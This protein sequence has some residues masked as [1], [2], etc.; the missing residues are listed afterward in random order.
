M[1]YFLTFLL[2]QRN[3][4]ICKNFQNLSRHPHPK[5]HPSRRLYHNI[6]LSLFL[7]S[8]LGEVLCWRCRGQRT[9]SV[10]MMMKNMVLL[11]FRSPLPI[12]STPPHPSFLFFHP[13]TPPPYRNPRPQP[14]R[15]PPLHLPLISSPT[16]SD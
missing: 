11:T 16:P 2:D 1:F 14:P 8:K 13:P 7:G 5:T 3:T 4:S 6:S 12:S 15:P 10:M 9:L